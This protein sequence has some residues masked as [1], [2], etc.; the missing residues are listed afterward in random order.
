MIASVSG[1]ATT[2]PCPARAWSAWPW[3]T[4][5]RATGLVGSIWK[6][7]GGQ[8]RPAGEGHRTLSGLGI[9]ENISPISVS[10]RGSSLAHLH[11]RG[12]LGGGTGQRHAVR[13]LGQARIDASGLTRPSAA[14]IPP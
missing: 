13:V 6:S 4:T 11:R 14:A 2:V 12:T 5:A 10:A 7:P 3:V 9:A 1:V 8:Y